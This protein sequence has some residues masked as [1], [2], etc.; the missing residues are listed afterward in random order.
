[1]DAGP[2][3]WDTVY[4]HGMGTSEKVL[5]GFLGGPP[6]GKCLVSD[7]F[8]PQCANPASATPVADMLDLQPGLMG[9]DR[10]DIHRIHNLVGAPTFTR[11]AG[12]SRTMRRSSRVWCLSRGGARSGKHGLAHSM[13]TGSA[14][15]ASVSLTAE[16]SG[17]LER[18]ADRLGLDAM[19][20]WEKERA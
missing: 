15:V 7:K 3:L 10:F 4:V 19:R 9:L 12:V 6:R 17:H 14:R 13:L 8:T 18:A 16:E 1:M 11:W 2:N 20:I 5:A